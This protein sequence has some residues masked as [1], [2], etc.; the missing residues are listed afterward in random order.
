[1]IPR[2]PPE[3]LDLLENL[4]QF[5]PTSRLSAHEALLHPYFTGGGLSAGGSAGYAAVP[6]PNAG[7]G[8]TAQ[9]VSETG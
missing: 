8:Y 3:A 1:M 9:Q 5:E 7:I 2:A 6:N 4:L